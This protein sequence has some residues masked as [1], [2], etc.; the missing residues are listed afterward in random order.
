LV[1]RFHGWR[2]A[3]LLIAAVGVLLRLRGLAGLGVV[4]HTVLW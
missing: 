4:R 2:L 3:G 1:R